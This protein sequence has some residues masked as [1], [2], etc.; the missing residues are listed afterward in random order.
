MKVINPKTLKFLR[1]KANLSQQ[2]LAEVSGVSKKTIARI[3]GGKPSANKT[4]TNRLAKALQV[5]DQELATL[6]HEKDG[7]EQL[8]NAVG[9][10][11]VSP[12]IIH[13]NAKLAM[14]MV[15]KCYGIPIPLQLGLAPL[16]AALLA[17]GSLSWRRQKLAMAKEAVDALD[18]ADYGHCGFCLGAGRADKM[19]FVERESIEQRDI[20]GEKVLEEASEDGLNPEWVNPFVEYLCHLAKELAKQSDGDLIKVV[21]G[22]KRDDQ[23]DPDGKW[24]ANS[25]HCPLSGIYFSIDESEL[26][27]LAGD[28][29]WASRALHWGCVKVADI[30]KEFLGDDAKEERMKWLESQIPESRRAEYEAF[31]D[32]LRIAV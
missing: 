18:E 19:A 8:L 21:P 29:E 17:E 6:P 9:Y 28:S 31:R 10:S 2:D 3:E 1:T 14:Q 13:N 12:Y 4:T 23:A 7:S 26:G 27:R 30:P 25:I 16:M 32:D 20:F 24:L 22:A 11:R 15:E 5:S